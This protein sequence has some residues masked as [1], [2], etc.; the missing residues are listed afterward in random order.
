M[1]YQA[2]AGSSALGI[3]SS[4]L[5]SIPAGLQKSPLLTQMSFKLEIFVLQGF[6]FLSE[7][8]DLTIRI[9]AIR[10]LLFRNHRVQNY[11]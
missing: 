6:V 3:A 4:L 10:G 7:L 2:T 8:F 9:R 11:C 1:N 5:Q